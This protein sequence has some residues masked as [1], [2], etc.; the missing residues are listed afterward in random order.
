MSPV[1][2]WRK[3]AC[4]PSGAESMPKLLPSAGFVGLT[5]VIPELPVNVQSTPTSVGRYSKLPAGVKLGV[6]N[7]GFP[8]MTP[9]QPQPHIS[10]TMAAILRKRITLLPIYIL[11]HITE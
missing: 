5:D 11:E 10:S 7:E 9:A 4:V 3:A 8:T 1:P 6:S 2:F